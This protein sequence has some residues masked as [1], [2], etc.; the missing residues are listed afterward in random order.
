MTDELKAAPMRRFAPGLTALVLLAALLIPAGQASDASADATAEM[1]ISSVP[2]QLPN[3]F[4]VF[5]TPSE[6]VPPRLAEGIATINGQPPPT[7]GHGFNVAL[8]QEITTPGKHAPLW[9][10]PGRDQLSIWDLSKKP[11]L[12]GAVATIV[13]SARKGL[14]FS[15]PVPHASHL[16][17][18]KGLVPDGITAVKLSRSAVAP[19]L[20][21]A[22][23]R[24]VDQKELWQSR[25]WTF[26]RRR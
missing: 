1:P 21:N 22:F 17:E 7:G 3:N 23:D 20:G 13:S 4:S 24:R 2:Q 26:T 8:G 10:I 9:A 12:W 15:T 19:V 25:S 11:A 14:A 16:V 5:R 6:A 18:V